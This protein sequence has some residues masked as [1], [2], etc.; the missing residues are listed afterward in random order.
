MASV[1][2]LKALS[3]PAVELPPDQIY[4]GSAE[5][6]RAVRARVLRAAGLDVPILI[7]GE[8]GTGKEVLARFVHANS[9]WTGGPFIKVNCPAIPGT[10]LESELFGYAKGAFTGAVNS[11]PGRIELAQGG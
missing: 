9:P 8:S 5:V 3:F 10:L 4:F 2:E 11:K 6:M 1:A 7:L